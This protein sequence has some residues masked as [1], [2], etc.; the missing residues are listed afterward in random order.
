MRNRVSFLGVNGLARWVYADPIRGFSWPAT[1]DVRLGTLRCS[2][3]LAPGFA[4][5][6][7]ETPAA[8]G[9]RRTCTGFARQV[10]S[11][12][13]CDPRPKRTAL[14]EPANLRQMLSPRHG[15][16]AVD[17]SHFSHLL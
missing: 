7:F 2:M 3:L 13:R 1:D 12:A 6:Y 5:L 17:P 10:P 4:I 14:H 16:R 15:G 8:G 9:G 11:P